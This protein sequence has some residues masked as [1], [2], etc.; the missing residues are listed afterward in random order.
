MA[1]ETRALVAESQRLEK[2]VRDNSLN[3]RVVGG[4]TATTIAELEDQI[5]F[6]DAQLSQAQ[7][8]R[9]TSR[10]TLDLWQE[11]VRLLDALAN[12]QTTRVAYVGL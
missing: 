5:G 10:D 9:V 1:R 12:V 8:S 3:G 2:F 11:R 6:V 4:Q 7:T